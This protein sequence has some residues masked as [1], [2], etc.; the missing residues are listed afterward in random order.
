MNKY[1]YTDNSK[2]EIVFVCEAENILEADKLYEETTGFNVVKQ[3]YIGC[4]PQKLS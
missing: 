4:E 1:V 3:S 2:K